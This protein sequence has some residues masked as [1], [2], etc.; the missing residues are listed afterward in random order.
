MLFLGGFSEFAVDLFCRVVQLLLE[1]PKPPPVRIR[2]DFST[3]LGLGLGCDQW[4]LTCYISRICTTAFRQKSTVYIW[5]LK[6]MIIILLVLNVS[7]V[8]S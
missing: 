3:M 6:F 7:V 4:V 1:L 5:A 2:D 8:D